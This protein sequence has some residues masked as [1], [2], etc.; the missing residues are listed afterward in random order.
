[1]CNIR[2]YQVGI[3]RWFI[4]VNQEGDSMEKKGFVA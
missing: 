4:F 2:L 3:K 1:M